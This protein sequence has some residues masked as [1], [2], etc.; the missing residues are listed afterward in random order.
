MAVRKTFVIGDNKIPV[1]EKEINFKCFSGLS[2]SQKQKSIDH[3]ISQKK[4][5]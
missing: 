2:L 1:I 4:S 3:F 5:N